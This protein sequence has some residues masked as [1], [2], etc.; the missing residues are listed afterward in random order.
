MEKE[1]RKRR[2]KI[3]HILLLLA[4][5]LIVINL[6]KHPLKGN[7]YDLI[8]VQAGEIEKVRIFH[9]GRTVTVSDPEDVD[10][11]VA[12]FDCHLNRLCSDYLGHSTGGDWLVTFVTTTGNLS[13][14][15]CPML[16]PEETRLHFDHYYYVC[17]EKSSLDILE[18]HWNDKFK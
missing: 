7:T 5:V 18:K 15:I 3:W 6:I 9:Y 13:K 11:L 14:T 2:W 1:K 4:V 10:T 17:D 8:G 16:Y 12:L